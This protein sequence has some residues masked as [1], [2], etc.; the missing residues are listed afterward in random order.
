MV[1]QVEMLHFIYPELKN[2]A[3]DIIQAQFI[4]FEIHKSIQILDFWFLQN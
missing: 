1:D 2:F 3:K 4:C